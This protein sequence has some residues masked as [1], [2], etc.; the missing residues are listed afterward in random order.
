MEWLGAMAS[1]VFFSPPGGRARTP[2]LRPKLGGLGLGLA[3]L[4]DSLA[5]IPAVCTQALPSAHSAEA[6]SLLR[7]VGYHDPTPFALSSLY[8]QLGTAPVESA[9]ASAFSIPATPR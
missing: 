2:G 4:S 1:G 3:Q 8:Q 5:A 9:P 7:S 6:T